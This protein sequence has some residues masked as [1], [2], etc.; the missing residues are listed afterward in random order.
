MKPTGTVTF[1]FAD[2]VVASGIEDRRSPAVGP[3]DRFGPVI[4]DVVVRNHGIVY[5]TSGFRYC[6]AFVLPLDAVIAAN[7]IQ[8]RLGSGNC[9]DIEP[10]VFRMAVHTGEAKESDGNYCGTTISSVLQLLSIARPGEILISNSVETLVTEFLPEDLHFEELPYSR[11]TPRHDRILQLRRQPVEKHKVSFRRPR[12]HVAFSRR[13]G[14]RGS[15]PA[16]APAH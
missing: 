12:F 1:L 2:I 13:R 5:R 6:C 9:I 15:V 3:A 16:S 4:T 7:Q 10:V 8:S 11:E 14:S